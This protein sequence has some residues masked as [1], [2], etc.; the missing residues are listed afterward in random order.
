MPVRDCLVQEVM[1]IVTV[2]LAD[3]IYQTHSA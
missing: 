2:Y 3:R 1:I